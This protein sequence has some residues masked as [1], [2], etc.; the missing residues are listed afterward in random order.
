MPGCVFS[1][2]K[3]VH[4]D[5]GKR[6]G[7]LGPPVHADLRRRLILSV[8]YQPALHIQASSLDLLAPGLSILMRV[9]AYECSANVESDG[10]QVAFA[11]STILV[12]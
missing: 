12:A 2:A 11:I 5:G 6:T 8:R 10:K 7:P 1:R 3:R 4:P 9:E